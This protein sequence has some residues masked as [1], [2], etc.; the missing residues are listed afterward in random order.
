MISGCAFRSQVEIVKRW[1]SHRCLPNGGSTNKGEI[2]I[3]NL[4][5]KYVSCLRS[6]I[7]ADPSEERLG[8]KRNWVKDGSKNLKKYGE[9][10]VGNRCKNVEKFDTFASHPLRLVKCHNSTLKCQAKEAGSPLKLQRILSIIT[11]S[12]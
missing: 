5:Q 12:P 9:N 7:T 10:T 3:E 8:N 4:I 6:T 1:V 11:V 2:L